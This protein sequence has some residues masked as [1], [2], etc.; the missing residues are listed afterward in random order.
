MVN[1]GQEGYRDFGNSSVGSESGGQMVVWSP[2]RRLLASFQE[3]F[4]K[5][6][7]EISSELEAWYTQQTEAMIQC[8]HIVSIWSA[9]LADRTIIYLAAALNL[10]DE[11]EGLKRSIRNGWMFTTG[12][13]SANA[14]AAADRIGEEYVVPSVLWGS[15]M[16]CLH[17]SRHANWTL[18]ESE[19][20]AA[21]L[22]TLG[23]AASAAYLS[24]DFHMLPAQH[25]AGLGVIL[26]PFAYSAFARLQK[27]VRKA[28]LPS[29]S[30]MKLYLGIGLLAAGA[31]CLVSA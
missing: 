6:S 24:D 14:R 25:R 28:D 15:G 13:I 11:G 22:F 18:V 3:Y 4:P 10:P 20:V 2:I 30:V 21:S 17:S 1:I 16:L 5:I 7:D 9:Q 12:A 23:L 27:S 31:G 26:A 8:G 19:P 29:S